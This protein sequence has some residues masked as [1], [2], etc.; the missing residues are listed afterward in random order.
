M[1]R[2]PS[3]VGVVVRGEGRGSWLTVTKGMIYRGSIR[4]KG[5]RKEKEVVVKIPELGM[6]S[7]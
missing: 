5:E 6:N 1:W 7:K 2:E 4:K 3:N